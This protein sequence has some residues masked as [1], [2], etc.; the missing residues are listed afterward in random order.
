MRSN[1]I[2][3]TRCFLQSDTLKASD[4]VFSDTRIMGKK[5]NKGK[6][7]H[8][9]DEKLH[10]S[11]PGS[12]ERNIAEGKREMDAYTWYGPT[13]KMHSAPRS[14]NGSVHLKDLVL[15][16]EET[17]AYRLNEIAR[18]TKDLRSTTQHPTQ[19]QPSVE[20]AAATPEGDLQQKES[21][22]MLRFTQAELEGY[23][24]QRQEGLAKKSRDWILRSS[25]TLWAIS[26]GE[27]SY[28]TVNAL[29]SYVLTRWESADSHLKV[30]GFAVRF[31]KFLASTKRD[32]RYL[33]SNYTLN[34]RE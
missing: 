30:L 28:D 23:T 3:P 10:N 8:N 12:G 33:H 2:G 29:R 20:G 32:Q 1:R 7:L 22:S 14:E 5:H 19:T 26:K 4:R 6:K 31:L 9:F 15:D 17:Y 24:A 25:E 16:K 34:V 18:H 11:D 13:G 27:I 21:S